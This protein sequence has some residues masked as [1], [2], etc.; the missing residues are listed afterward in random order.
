MGIMNRVN[1]LSHSLDYRSSVNSITN[2][3]H[4]E[5]DSIP[6]S[7]SYMEGN[8]E[9]LDVLMDSNSSKILNGNESISAIGAVGMTMDDA[10]SYIK[11]SFAP[12]V[13]EGSSILGNV[14]KKTGATLAT[15]AI[16]LVEGIAKTG[17]AIVDTASI[18]SAATYSVAV[19]AIDIIYNLLGK[20][21][22]KTYEFN[23]QNPNEFWEKTK[24]FVSKKGVETA[25]DQ[26]YEQNSIGQS[27]KNNS[28]FFDT[29]RNIGKG[30][31]SILS[32]SAFSILGVGFLNGGIQTIAASQ[33][34]TGAGIL[35][36]A[37]G[38]EDAWSEGES[39][40][41]GLK[42]GLARGLIDAAKY[43][44]G[45]KIA[46]LNIFGG[47]ATENGVIYTLEEQKVN[48]LCRI[49][50]NGLDG[51]SD[52]V[53]Q[54]FINAICKN[55]YKDSTGNILAFS[56]G[57]DFFDKFTTFFDQNGGFAAILAGAAIGAGLTYFGER[58]NARKLIKDHPDYVGDIKSVDIMKDRDKLY[59]IWKGKLDDNLSFSVNSTETKTVKIRDILDY[60][61]SGVESNDV[62]HDQN[63]AAHAVAGLLKSNRFSK[64]STL[65][66]DLTEKEDLFSLQSSL[67][68]FLVNH[69]NSYRPDAIEYQKYIKTDMI[70]ELYSSVGKYLPGTKEEQIATIKDRCL[71]T[72][73]LFEG[74]VFELFGF[75]PGVMGFNT[76]TT[77]CV[78]LDPRLDFN[79][80]FLA[81]L[82][83]LTKE[84]VIST[85]VKD[86]IFHENLH[87]ISTNVSNNTTG[88]MVD[89]KLRALNEAATE[90]IAQHSRADSLWSKMKLTTGYPDLEL[91]FIDL[92]HF[93]PNFLERLEQYY[94]AQ[95][96][97][98]FR[99]MLTEGTDGWNGLTEQESHLILSMLSEFRGTDFRKLIEWKKFIASKKGGK[100]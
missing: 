91:A 58:T 97:K 87:Q 57:T 14:I 73:R 31:G 25:F 22:G 78:N 48:S 44:I 53:L 69:Y 42:Y 23:H 39:I 96:V 65:T 88:F 45:G 59:H 71:D 75:S 74:D 6:D 62:F 16:S 80:K 35:G 90:Y 18:V 5:N 76:G 28:L 17:E 86:I 55:N 60:L 4:H 56:E 3:I 47:T 7:F 66:L 36:V 27:I 61:S 77:S 11:N 84:E 93:S 54:P 89:W 40:S 20:I 24:N 83:K 51:A 43:Y 95:D 33:L 10:S 99:S 98:G 37:R 34:A 19:C 79:N 52:G 64:L 12:A 70:D 92:E 63:E 29:V 13:K 8:P 32:T 26:F 38:T 15:G 46:N 1:N 30:V 50:L 67:A 9:E 94:M 85:K 81:Y 49:G 82:T 72:V 2:Q 68:E 21:T 41:D 100:S